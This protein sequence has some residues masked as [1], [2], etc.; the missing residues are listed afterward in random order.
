MRR[1]SAALGLGGAAALVTFIIDQLAKM[2]WL[3]TPESPAGFSYLKGWIQSVVHQNEG[4]TFNLPLPQFF[5][6][7]ITLIAFVWLVRESKQAWKN[8]DRFGLCCLGLV[9]GGAVGNAYDR[10]MFGYVRDW[11]LL[12]HRSAVNIADI[13]IL[14]GVLGYLWKRSRTPKR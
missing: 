8:E 3:A 9:L 12:W 6:L 10:V 5:I 14:V 11:L 1:S 4:I 7:L 13:A 2:R